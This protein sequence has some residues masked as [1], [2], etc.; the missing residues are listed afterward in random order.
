MFK[1]IKLCNESLTNANSAVLRSWPVCTHL[2]LYCAL[3]HIEP[4]Q[5]RVEPRNIAQH[6]RGQRRDVLVLAE[7]S[8][9]GSSW[10]SIVQDVVGCA[11]H[12][13]YEQ[14]RNVSAQNKSRTQESS[15]HGPLAGSM[16]E[17]GVSSTVLKEAALHLISA[18]S[19]V[20]RRWSRRA[21]DNPTEYRTGLLTQTISSDAKVSPHLC[22]TSALGCPLS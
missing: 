17:P 8:A 12:H 15:I 19:P 9:C 13:V 11:A 20:Y 18:L 4:Q 16:V 21:T 1:P 3:I 7:L 14:V 2:M 10:A 6:R 22:P 5:A